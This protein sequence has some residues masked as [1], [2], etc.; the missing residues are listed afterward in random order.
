MNKK[1]LKELNSHLKKQIGSK[2]YKE[3]LE[4]KEKKGW[5]NL[6]KI[7]SIKLNSIAR[8]E[9]FFDN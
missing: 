9:G 7:L 5:D 6:A 8:K 4:E 2:R 3:I 1:L